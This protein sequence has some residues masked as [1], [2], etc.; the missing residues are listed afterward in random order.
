MDETKIMN[1]DMARGILAD[2]SVPFDP[3]LRKQRQ[4]QGPTGPRM[5]DYV[6][7]MTV[8]DRLNEVCPGWHCTVKSQDV[9]PFG[10]TNRGDA[11]LMLTAVVSLYI[12][13]VGTRE[14]MGVQVVN[15]DTGGEDLWKGAISDALKKAASLFGVGRE[16]YGDD[17]ISAPA[18]F[19]PP[20][21]IHPGGS[22]TQV[23]NQPPQRPP[24]VN[25]TGGATPRQ[26]EW[27]EVMCYEKGFDY[28][29]YTKIVGDIA[30]RAG[31]S[32]V[33]DELK[34]MPTIN[35]LERGQQPPDE[36]RN[37]PPF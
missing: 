10:T 12:P 30:D 1:D 34:A 35:R 31:A 8:V 11:R 9:R 28:A 4:V 13:E 25:S 15:A 14:H 20:P 6:D 29:E 3:S 33:I 23:V 2:L 5:L 27:I 7:L 16:M 36:W 37:Q 24:M 19:G 17:P 18:T 32:R 22:V 26:L 21:T